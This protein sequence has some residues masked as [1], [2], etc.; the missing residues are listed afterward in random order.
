MILSSE[1]ATA[2]TAPQRTPATPVNTNVFS[3][4]GEQMSS[5]LLTLEGRNLQPAEPFSG[6]AAIARFHRSVVAD[7]RASSHRVMRTRSLIS[8][9]QD[10]YFKVMWQVSGRNRIEHRGSTLTIEPG[11]WTIYDTAQPYSV[12]TSEGSHFLVLLLPVSQVH[13]SNPGIDFVAGKVL[14]TRGTA[15]IARSALAGMLAGGV[16]LEQEGA[17]VMQDSISALIGAAVTQ[18][19]GQSTREEGAVNRRL[20]KLQAYIES[21]LT[22]PELCPEAV[23]QACAMSRRS[24]YTAFNALGQTPNSFILQ[25]RLAVAAQRLADPQLRTTI[26]QLAFELGF[27]DAAHFSRVFSERYGQSPS[28]WR[29]G[30]KPA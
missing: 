29:E 10:R 27:S 28:H 21:H 30:R 4:W 19:C 17:I 5:Q 25:R 7:I 1:I 23:A 13:P 22:D 2:T 8:A 15:E 9:D 11:E 14:P 16:E 12:D 18:V 3:R 24:L 26:T 6:R 20:Q